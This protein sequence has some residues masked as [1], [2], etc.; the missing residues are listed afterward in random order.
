MRAFPKGPPVLSIAVSRYAPAR[1][2]RTIL[3]ET[4]ERNPR[5][6]Q[7]LVEREVSEPRSVKL[8]VEQEV[9]EPRSIKTTI[10]SICP[11]YSLK[12]AGHK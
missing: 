11:D 5:S 2:S 6:V 10:G 9:S 1:I 7:L 8:H 4:P 12:P 3:I